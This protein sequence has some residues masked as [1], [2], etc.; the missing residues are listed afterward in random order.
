MKACRIKYYFNE[1]PFNFVL[2]IFML[3]VSVVTI[4]IEV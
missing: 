4:L 1:L 3:P 2:I